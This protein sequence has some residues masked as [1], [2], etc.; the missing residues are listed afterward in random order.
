M[1]S[2]GLTARQRRRLRE[3]LRTTRDAHVYRR[4]LAL[5]ELDRGQAVE[6]VA[7][8]L[9]VH[10]RTVYRWREAFARD[11]DPAALADAD[12]PGRP[13]LWDAVDREFLGELL[14]QPPQDLGYAA[15]DW[16]VPLL[17]DYLEQ[18]LG[19]RFS[20]DTIR[21]ELRRQD[22]VWKRPRYV[23][24]PDPDAEK[25]TADP[26]ATPR[27]ARR[28][29]GPGRGRDGPAAVPAAAGRVV[30]AGPTQDRRAVGPERPAG[31]VRGAEPADRAAGVPRPLA[32][33]LVWL[34][35]RVPK[36]NPMDTLWGRAK[37]VVSANR[38]YETLDEHVR[39]FLEHLNG[40]TDGEALTAA[41][42]CSD[43]F[44][45]RSVL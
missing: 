1:S 12:R 28:R 18:C 23:L 32:V 35:K 43:D 3:Q 7:R 41:G 26:P 17:Q 40:L 11:P 22:Y 15:A 6:H 8:T 31:R 14:G 33:E 2:P 36:L 44:W 42:T 38:Q 24:D 20:A 16:D 21:R 4:A 19:R 25:K 13:S 27:P 45:L 34:P 9:G 29:G 10:R 30:Q 37:D 5:L 39:R